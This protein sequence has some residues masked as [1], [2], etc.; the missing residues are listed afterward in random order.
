MTINQH[1]LSRV[2][3]Y[4]HAQSN[5]TQFALPIIDIK[6]NTWSTNEDY[7]ETSMINVFDKLVQQ[8]LLIIV[9]D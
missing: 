2:M 7:R 3:I 4:A 6:I 8:I 9:H 1:K 5:T